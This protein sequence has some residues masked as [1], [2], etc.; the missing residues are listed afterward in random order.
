MW[1]KRLCKLCWNCFLLKGRPAHFFFYLTAF[2]WVTDCLEINCLEINGVGCGSFLLRFRS[3][4]KWLKQHFG[5]DTC[6][7]N[8]LSVITSSLNSSG[9]AAPTE[10]GLLLNSGG[11]WWILHWRQASAV[12]FLLEVP[13]RR[14][15]TSLSL[16]SV[17]QLDTDM[18]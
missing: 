2:P 4:S 10:F 13:Q 17:T 3:N 5:S 1:V 18:K 7:F 16:L 8:L 14:I 6:E 12:C 9:A 11:R 15:L